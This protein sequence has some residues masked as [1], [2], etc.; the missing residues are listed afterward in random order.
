MPIVR[1]QRN[2][3]FLRNR[4]GLYLIQDYEPGFDAWSTKYA[5]AESTYSRDPSLVF[6]IYNS[7]ELYD[8]FKRDGYHFAREIYFAPVLNNKLAEILSDKKAENIK[9]EKQII[10]YGRPSDERNAFEIIR[11]ALRLWSEQYPS[12]SEW[13][14][15]SLGEWFDNIILS[16]NV[17]ESQGKA[18]LEEYAEYM[19][20]SYIGISLMI[21]PHPSYPPL[22]MSTFGVK[23]ITNIFAN[24]DLST[25][26]KNIISLR[27]YMPENIAGKLSELCDSYSA[28]NSKM[29]LNESYIHNKSFN[30]MVEIVEEQLNELLSES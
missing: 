25:F 26:N 9:R 16:N 23:I 6:A 21:S 4:I 19:L 18:S 12:A 17:I 24:K 5:L 10:I 22:E 15:I 29:I 8:Y 3:Y 2:E 20:S 11:Y 27:N 14:I 7:E 30:R 1:W 28:E 13:K